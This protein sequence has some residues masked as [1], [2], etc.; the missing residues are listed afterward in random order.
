MNLGRAVRWTTWRYWA[1]AAV[2]VG[3]EAAD[4]AANVVVVVVV[5]VEIIIMMM[6]S[7]VQFK[8]VSMRSEKPVRAPPHLTLRSFPNIVFETVPMSV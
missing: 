5:V 3:V 1:I 7:S 2:L 6:I 8:M 4:G